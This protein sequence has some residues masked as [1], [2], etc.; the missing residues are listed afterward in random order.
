MAIG[1][2]VEDGFVTLS[3]HVASHAE[4]LAAEHTSARLRGV[5]A[6]WI[7]VTTG[8]RAAETQGP[9]DDIVAHFEVLH[10]VSEES[11]RLICPQNS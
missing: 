8:V 2:T 4:K 6:M 1:A 5:K 10:L 7:G 9:A 3:G 11:R